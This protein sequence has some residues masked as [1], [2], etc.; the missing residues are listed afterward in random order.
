VQLITAQ[1]SAVLR[2][3]AQFSVVQRSEVHRST[4]Q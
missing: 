1:Y 2:S 4:A 3:T